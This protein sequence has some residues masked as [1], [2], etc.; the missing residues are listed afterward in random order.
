MIFVENLA[1]IDFFNNLISIL[2]DFVV[3]ELFLV[4][5]GGLLEPQKS[6]NFWSFP[7]SQKKIKNW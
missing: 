4:I 2:M 7:I 1:L 3:E 5:F 6:P